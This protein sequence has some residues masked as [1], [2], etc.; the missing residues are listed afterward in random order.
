MLRVYFILLSFS[1]LHDEDIV[2]VKRNPLNLA[3][4]AYDMT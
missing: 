2:C 4:Q 1:P 3:K